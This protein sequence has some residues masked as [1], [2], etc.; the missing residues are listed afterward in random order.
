MTD[1]ERF[2]RQLVQTL[3]ATEPMRLRQP[4]PIGEI[5]LNLLPYRTN[6]RALELDTSEDYELVLLRLCAGEGGFA[7]AEPAETRTRFIAE[8][9]SSHPDLAV[10]DRDAASEI[11]LVQEQVAFALVPGD[12]HRAYAPPGTGSATPWS[13]PPFHEAAPPA[14]APDPDDAL[15]LD[16]VRLAPAPRPAPAVPDADDTEATSSSAQCSYCGGGLPDGRIVNFCPH[17]GQSQATTHCPECRTEVEL[18]WRHCI[19]CGF[20]LAG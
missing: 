18:G 2:F 6:R 15:P 10:L 9:A 7:H 5:R 20:A 17:C 4:I 12:T 13:A 11:T 19:T 14:S 1:L 8:V 16:E 3:A